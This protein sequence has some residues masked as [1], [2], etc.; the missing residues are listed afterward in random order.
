V[1]YLIEVLIVCRWRYG[2]AFN[3][4]SFVLSLTVFVICWA[5]AIMRARFGWVATLPF[6]AISLIVSLT[7]LKRLLGISLNDIVKKFAKPAKKG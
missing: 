7:G 6:V 5:T 3:R 1:L 4:N 2:I